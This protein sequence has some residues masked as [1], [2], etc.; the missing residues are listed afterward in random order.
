MPRFQ[1]I[2]NGTFGQVA[3]SDGSKLEGEVVHCDQDSLTVAVG[4]EPDPRD[5]DDLRSFYV[6][7]VGAVV[8]Y[9]YATDD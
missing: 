4:E 7:P 6:V 5:A 9:R 2:I 1:E 3:L 8:Y